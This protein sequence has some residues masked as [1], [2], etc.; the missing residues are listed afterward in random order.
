VAFF[1]FSRDKRG[2]EHFYLMQPSTRGKIRPRLLYWFR[3]PPNIKVGRGP[4]EP[5]I[6]RAIESQFPDI[7]FDWKAIAE[8]PIPPADAERWRERRRQERASRVAE[9]PPEAEPDV[10]SRAESAAAEPPEAELA[11]ETTAAESSGT[12]NE[13]G[14]METRPADRPAGSRKRRRRRGRRRSGG[15]RLPGDLQDPG[16]PAEPAEKNGETEP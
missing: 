5:E 16:V 3:T 8:T 11:S 12:S 9:P 14:A 10:E 2:Y 13:R 6:R 1:R 7:V 4:F 15:D